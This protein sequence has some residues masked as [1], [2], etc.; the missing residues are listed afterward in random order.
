VEAKLQFNLW[1]LALSKQNNDEFVLKLKQRCD[2]F[3][4]P[5]VWENSQ[6]FSTMTYG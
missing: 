2:I 3:D 5:H 6:T 1:E 4:A